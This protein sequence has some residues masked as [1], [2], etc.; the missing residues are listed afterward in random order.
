MAF[1]N[2]RF[3]QVTFTQAV[4]LTDD[5]LVELGSAWPHLEEFNVNDDSGWRSTGELTLH[6]LVRSS[7]HALCYIIFPSSVT[8]R[9][10]RAPHGA[11]IC[12]ILTESE[13]LRHHG[14]FGMSE[15][16]HELGA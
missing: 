6:G 10:L 1:G 4:R 7:E 13:C 3:L 8:P 15:T 12:R 2:L 11:Q 14:V 9:P 16:K 5:D